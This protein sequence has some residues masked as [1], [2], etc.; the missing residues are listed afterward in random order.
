MNSLKKTVGRRWQPRW[1]WLLY[2]GLLTAC[3]VLQQTDQ[4][5][6]KITA[7]QQHG[8]SLL[9]GLRQPTRQRITLHHK[10]WLSPK[11]LTLPTERLPAAV[12]CDITL[13]TGAPVPLS[14]LSKLINKLC[15]LSLRLT[16][17]AEAK[18]Q[19]QPNKQTP[20][21]E[22][23]IAGIRWQGKLE[24]LLDEVAST[25]GLS[26]RY[27]QASITLYYI[28]SRTF[29]IYAIPSKTEMSSMI[30]SG[31]DVGVVGND[32]ASKGSGQSSQQTRVSRRC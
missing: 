32:S 22:P 5:S 26:W 31:I 24:G 11:A 4:L 23:T 19:Q 28:D 13:A 1:L 8:E 9:Q 20:Y 18:L 2:S 16:P 30:N 3:S 17:D 15:G 14:E 6:K 25:L 12:N 10:P 27:Q 21:D 7:E 29:Q